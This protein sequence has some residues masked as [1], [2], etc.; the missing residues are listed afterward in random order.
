MDSQSPPNEYEF[1]KKFDIYM[2]ASKDLDQRLIEIGVPRSDTFYVGVSGNRL[3]QGASEKRFTEQNVTEN[4]K[5]ILIHNSLGRHLEEKICK[6]FFILV[7]QMP[8]VKYTYITEKPNYAIDCVFLNYWLNYNIRE[9]HNACDSCVQEF[10]EKFQVSF[11]DF[12]RNLLSQCSVSYMDKNEFENMK[13]LYYLHYYYKRIYSYL[14]SDITDDTKT[15]LD[16]I[17]ECISNYSKLKVMCN[18]KS[19]NLCKALEDFKNELASHFSVSHRSEKCDKEHLKKLTDTVGVTGIFNSSGE[20]SVYIDSM[21]SGTSVEGS[22]LE[23]STYFS[24]I[25]IDMKKLIIYIVISMFA[26]LLIFFYTY[27]N[28]P[29]GSRLRTTIRRKIID[30]KHMYNKNNNSTLNISEDN[31]R[32]SNI[33]K[34]SILYS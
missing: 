2:E 20:Q 17:N 14:F 10:Y 25:T 4:C 32:V 29:F 27:M 30:R 11:S 16:C 33:G 23:N 9:N 5:S 8:S 31:G 26:M 21:L 6:H 22:T 3:P 15:C 19:T 13:I 24:E 28:I 7:N 1:F 34:Y 18:N 12:N